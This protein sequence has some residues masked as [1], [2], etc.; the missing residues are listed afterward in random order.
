MPVRSFGPLTVVGRPNR[1]FIEVRRGD[2]I[3]IRASGTVDVGGAFLGIGAPV[4]GPCRPRWPSITAYEYI[5]NGR[6][7]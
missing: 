2:L 7:D 6:F 1:T 4:L 3:D 5:L